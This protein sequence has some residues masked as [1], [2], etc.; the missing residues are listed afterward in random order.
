[1]VGV[2][3]LPEVRRGYP[4]P[5]VGEHRVRQR[6]EHVGVRLDV[7]VGDA[8]RVGPRVTQ[9]QVG[10]GRIPQITLFEPYPDA[11]AGIPEQIALG[12]VGGVVDHCHLRPDA[13]RARE[14]LRRR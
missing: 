5:L 14:G 13:R 3:A 2:A 7:G 10:G 11:V 12:L 1:M 4:D 8:D 6:P 9:S